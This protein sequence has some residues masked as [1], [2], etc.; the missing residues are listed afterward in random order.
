MPCRSAPTRARAL[1]AQVVIGQ[2]VAHAVLSAGHRLQCWLTR[3]V[4][5][6]ASGA[7][8]AG[9]PWSTLISQ[10]KDGA[11]DDRSS[12]T[13]LGDR[14]RGA[15]VRVEHVPRHEG[16]TRRVGQARLPAT[17]EALRTARDH[18]DRRRPALGHY[19]RAGRRGQGLADLPGGD[20]QLSALLH[21]AVGRALRLGARARQD[22]R[23]PDRRAALAGRT[24]GPFRNRIGNPPRRAQRPGD[25]QPR[26]LLLPR[27]GVRRDRSGRGQG[28]LRRARRSRAREAVGPEGP[29]S[30]ERAGATRGLPQPAGPG[31]E[32][33][34]RPDDRDQPGV[35]AGHRAG[36]A[37]SR[38]GRARGVRRQPSTGLHWPR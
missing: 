19:R 12:A 9:S 13:T 1:H 20:Q 6:R 32:G 5:R 27:P 22:L 33:S 26:L 28:R 15:C 14:P 11:T 2:S 35:S 37:L 34:R 25:G 30:P 8:S 4:P 7:R 36:P 16:G 10:W 29:H 17:A 38:G 23:R 21:R 31:R 18:L 3:V 24:P